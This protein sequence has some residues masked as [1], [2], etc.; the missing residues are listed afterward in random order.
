[1]SQHLYLQRIY[2]VQQM[3][4]RFEVLAFA[5]NLASARSFKTLTLSYIYCL[6]R[7]VASQ[8]VY[9]VILL[10][11]WMSLSTSSLSA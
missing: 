10:Y 6:R 9:V 4:L 1:M 7:L 8:S 3:L 5:L 2:W 11:S